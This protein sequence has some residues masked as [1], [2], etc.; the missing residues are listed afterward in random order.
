MSK[1]KRFD[2]MRDGAGYRIDEDQDG[3]YVLHTDYERDV[4]EL[5][6]VL[7]NVLTFSNDPSV[8]RMT[9][10]ALSKFRGDA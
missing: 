10:E 1:V 4:G 8:I 3:R 9:R 5:V 2:L 6:A 7:E